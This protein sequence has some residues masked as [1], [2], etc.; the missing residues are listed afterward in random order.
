M[1][2][3]RLLILGLCLTLAGAAAALWS[4]EIPMRTPESLAK[5]SSHIAVGSVRRVYESREKDGKYE[6]THFVAE[7]LVEDFERGARE[8]GDGPSE[9]LYV[10]WQR[11]RWVGRGMPPP[12]SSGH[13]GWVPEAGDRVRVY[14]EQGTSTWY[15]KQDGAYTVLFPNGFEELEK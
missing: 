14:L 1:L 7:L 15:P 3:K 12:G 8:F 10:R 4:P 5:G 2:S 9:P 6:T 13:Y 11:K